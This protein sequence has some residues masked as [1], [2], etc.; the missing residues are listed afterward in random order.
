MP[1]VGYPFSSTLTHRKLT[2]ELDEKTARIAQLD[3]QL[4]DLQHLCSTKDQEIVS[5]KTQTNALRKDLAEHE[6]V[7]HTLES[8]CALLNQTVSESEGRVRRLQCE[9]EE[10]CRELTDLRGLCDRLER[11]SHTTQ[12][13]LT[14]GSLETEQLR[15]QLI[16]AEREL[17]RLRKQV[18]TI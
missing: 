7:V 5:W 17:V 14:T 12:H 9:N 18:H 6:Q 2:L 13:Q 4:T 11:Q 3:S 8:Q 1:N 16:E 10:T 15:A